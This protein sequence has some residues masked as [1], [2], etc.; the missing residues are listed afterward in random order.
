[1]ADY[2]ERG[3]TV[4][5]SALSA[6]MPRL[7]AAAAAVGTVVFIV[8][9][10]TAPYLMAGVMAVA[11]A[12]C[13]AAIGA[14]L[15]PRLPWP[16]T[17]L[18]VA[19]AYLVLSIAWSPS[20]AT[21]IAATAV[22]AVFILALSTTLNALPHIEEET[23]LASAQGLI[24]GFAIGGAFLLF[25]QLSGLW[26]HRVALSLIPRLHTGALRGMAERG[27]WVVHM[28]PFLLNRNMAAGAALF[29]PV[30][31]ALSRIP[32]SRRPG[33]RLALTLGPAAAAIAL[34]E[35]ATSQVAIT[36]AA[37][38]FAVA[39]FSAKRA[40]V[41]LAVIWTAAT[42]LVV[43]M[44]GGLYASG[45]YR[46]DWLPFSFRHRIVIWGYTSA[47]VPKA[48][49]LGAGIGAAHVAGR[50][51]NAPRAPGSEIALSTSWHS[52]NAYLQA[53]Y[54]TGAVAALLL[55]SFGLALLQAIGR[56]PPDTVPYLLAVFCA[57]ALAAAS[58]YSL[59]QSWVMG[60]MSL[61]AINAL[62]MVSLAVR[63]ERSLMC[64]ARPPPR[65]AAAT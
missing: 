44:A 9:P 10:L 49:I 8:A 36:G 43:P 14:L 21:A 24:A 6:N 33:L 32:N 23:L 13:G 31:L 27:G 65:A 58:S 56:S 3:A 59:W 48:P 2:I 57:G 25:E 53:W 37:V 29:W 19:E 22:L 12:A 41:A 40:R 51:P 4:Q 34:S 63:Q 1:M 16:M 7:S 61:A 18:C 64:E 35:H 47:Q 5:R 54:E 26:L 15:P 50:I 62:A 17:I 38:V 45:L 28:D 39:R 60:S 55:L 30:A 11:L 46:A 20:P 42:L 52:H